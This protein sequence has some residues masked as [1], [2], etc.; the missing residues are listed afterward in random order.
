MKKIIA[1]TLCA[2]MILSSNNV[3][4]NN[5][6]ANEVDESVVMLNKN[7]DVAEIS[8]SKLENAE[9]I[10]VSGE[11]NSQDEEKLNEIMDNGTGIIF[12]NEDIDNVIEYL[13]VDNVS[14]SKHELGCYVY[15]D[16][17]ETKLMPIEAN[18]LV[19]EG[20]EEVTTEKDYNNLLK[21]VKVDYGSVVETVE[22]T[23]NCDKFNSL[24]EESKTK[25]QSAHKLGSAFMG[26]EKTIYFYKKGIAGGN[27]TTY[28]YDTNSKGIDGWSQL[29]HIFFNVYAVKMKTIGKTTYDSV[30]SLVDVTGHN[31][32]YVTEYRTG[33]SYNDTSKCK[34]IDWSTP[35]DNTNKKC[36]IGWGVDSNGELTQTVSY[37]FNPNSMDI[38]RKAYAN[39]QRW[40]CIPMSAKDKSWDVN[41]GVVIKK[42]K[43]TTTTVKATSYVSYFQVS[44]GIRTYTIEDTASC[45]IKFKN[46]K[47]A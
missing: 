4:C 2:A 38:S 44:G 41:P 30:F 36:T 23:E 13:D 19:E 17:D 24:D 15:K 16:G 21:N 28:K 6:I 35:K 12:E 46:H 9:A 11:V 39:R 45:T 10:V 31:G 33:I 25:L 47:K 18:I 8:D 32:K 43:G 37:E 27:G 42:T 3:L 22:K 7:Q 29:G 20:T 34:I 40:T 26:A 5:V 14:D 1:L